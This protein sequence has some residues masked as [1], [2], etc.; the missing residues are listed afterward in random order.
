MTPALMIPITVATPA[1]IQ[2][3]L[4]NTDLHRTRSPSRQLIPGV[5]LEAINTTME[6]SPI[7]RA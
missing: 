4:F 3:L 6:L 1:P 2:Y 7:V 5:N